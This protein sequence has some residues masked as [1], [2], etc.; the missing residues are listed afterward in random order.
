MAEEAR[1]GR[2]SS[3]LLYQADE[4]PPPGLALG[5][6]GQL[7]VL[8]LAGVVFVPTITHRA[9]GSA[10]AVIAWAVFVSL[11]VTAAITA[12]QAFPIRRFGGGYLLV[13][14]TTAS[15][16]AIGT[17][18]LAAGGVGL[19]ATLVVATA[20]FQLVFASR[21]AMFR[22]ILTPSVSGT[23]LMLI[24]VSIVPILFDRITDVPPGSSMH[25]GFACAL[26]ALAVMVLVT[27][28]GGRRLRPWS[29]IVGMVAG[30]A[31]AAAYGI[32]DV[33]LVRDAAWVGI[34]SA[35]HLGLDID[36]GPSFWAL[37]P[38]FLLVSMTCTVRAMSAA[39][40]IQDVSW[41]TPRAPD[42]RTVQG[43]VAGDSLAN[44][45]A[46]LGGGLLM[47]TRSQTVGFVQI[48][49]VAARRVGLAFGALFAAIAFF[50]KPIALVLALPAGV[51]S[52]Y[53]MV[54]F[55]ALFVAG[56][57]MVVSDGLDHRQ[58]LIVGISFW[59][60][61]GCEFGLLAPELLSG[62]AGGLFENGLVV[63]GLMAIVLTAMLELSG[64]R[65]RRLE[66]DLDVASLGAI[67]EFVAVVASEQGW[68][69]TMASRLEAVAEETLLT[70]VEE[71]E[72]APRRR[73]RLSAHREGDSAVLEFVARPSESNI[74]DRIAMLGDVRGGEGMERD[75]S[76]R[77]LRHL[78]SDVRHRQYRDLD[79][80]AVRVE[81]SKVEPG[82]DGR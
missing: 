76:L 27:F 82:P 73:L 24:V 67:R 35:V 48:T 9:A 61:A 64:G 42:F 12:L 14:G 17:D 40:A 46:G 1:V 66:T 30:A 19:L 34:P 38:A 77:L 51:F 33:D 65:R 29:I 20:L 23:V 5:L 7:A 71:D 79:F 16:I 58:G 21:I 53:L 59:T 63:G 8:S 26:V 55:A 47:A 74:E 60:G 80:I 68:A 2:D 41:R 39:L 36:I 57:K 6:G 18:A 70:L 10:D 25:E 31:V 15:A 52:A 28:K 22:R 44:L 81:S 56:I 78:A 62:A 37:L 43:T 49:N 69:K 50:P 13:T 72:H 45:V 4:S 75:I 11:I 32:Y 54:M 3:R